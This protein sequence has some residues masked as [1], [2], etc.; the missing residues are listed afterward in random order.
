MNPKAGM[1][2]SAASG[3]KR[4]DRI[5]E[6]R[7]RFGADLTLVGHHYQADE[8]V[9]HCD[10]CGDSLELARRCAMLE[11]RYI[12]FC[13]VY[14]M[15]E[16]AALL[17]G[18]SVQVHLPEPS[19][20][21]SMALMSPAGLLRK[22]MKRLT[23]NGRKVIPLTY[24]NS[25]LGVKAV[26][27]EFGGAV[28]TSANAGTMLEWAL[29]EGDAVLFLPDKN[30]GRNT[31]DALGLSAED[32]HTA[33]ISRGGDDLD[34]TAA[35]GARLILWPGFCSIHTRFNLRQV[36]RLRAEHPGAKI[37]V[38]PECIPEVVAAADAVGSTAFLI[39]HI[40][41]APDDAVI[42]VGTEINLVER[43]ARRH[44]ERLTVLPLVESACTHMAQTTED[45]L[46]AALEAL[47]RAEDAGEESPCKVKI[48]CE[49]QAPARAALERM[50]E[51]CA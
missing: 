10:L 6:L 31:A 22:V 18:K 34:V 36:E 41:E 50:L 35:D 44:E 25:S 16:S 37:A 5:E 38:H 30:L 7:V 29:K 28:C 51:R 32:L 23:R 48:G 40:D 43:L 4:G 8:V 27:G 15:A 39:R 14:F 20:E 49:L 1:P 13:G 19:A 17:A 47:N 24:V 33:R 3:R 12:M 45:S 46:C 9:A 21:C 2:E 26:A 42:G 11:T